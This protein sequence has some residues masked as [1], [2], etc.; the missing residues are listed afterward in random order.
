MPPR[1]SHPNMLPMRVDLPPPANCLGTNIFESLAPDLR[2]VLFVCSE[3][4][5][6]GG[7]QNR[8]DRKVDL[9]GDTGGDGADGGQAFLVTQPVLARC[10]L[11][12]SFFNGCG[13]SFV[14]ELA[15]VGEFARSRSPKTGNKGRNPI[16]CPDL[17]RR[18]MVQVDASTRQISWPKCWIEFI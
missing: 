2:S 7:G 11:G 15:L 10:Q 4:R 9:V 18:E 3:G 12:G 5:K 17:V 13:E 1:R 16:A 14:L 6:L 8:P